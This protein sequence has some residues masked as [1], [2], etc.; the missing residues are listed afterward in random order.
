MGK[1]KT[2]A[3]AAEPLAA[4]VTV[5]TLQAGDSS[6]A[7]RRGD[8]VTVHYVGSLMDGTVFDSSRAKKAPFSFKLGGNGV[9]HGWNLGVAQMVLGQRANLTI[10]AKAAYGAAGCEDKA[11]A[12]GTGVIPPNADLRFDVELLDINFTSTLA[13]YR[14][15]L[16]A[17]IASKLEAFDGGDA[18]ARA[19][20]LAKHGSVDGY[21]T[22]LHGT[23]AKKYRK[24]REQKFASVGMD[25]SAGVAAGGND[26]DAAAVASGMSAVSLGA[27]AVP[28]STGAG[29]DNDDESAQAPEASPPAGAPPPSLSFDSRFAAI[30][31]EPND[32]GEAVAPNFPRSLHN[33]AELFIGLGHTQSAATLHGCVTRALAA[34]AAGP[35]GK[36]AK[37]IGRA[38]V[39]WGCGHVGLPKNADQCSERGARPA[40]VCAGCGEDGQ[41]N[42]VRVL[43]EG[44]KTV[45]WIECAEMSEAQAAK[46]EEAARAAEAAEQT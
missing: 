12:S 45:P 20:L 25:A 34:L 39:C 44:G 19:P 16:D 5:E 38:C 27:D 14:A 46:M 21:K 32:E 40:G 22:Y 23:A 31:V 18:E 3:A 1:K 2:K 8:A 9:I 4:P 41:T 6:R 11:N 24:E 13:K 33:A 28:K 15:T 10:A 26:D 42:F 37:A 43:Q 35:D 7:P 17:W 36:T 30:K 29:N